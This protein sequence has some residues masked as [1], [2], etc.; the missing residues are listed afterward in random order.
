MNN[1]NEDKIMLDGR[2]DNGILVIFAGTISRNRVAHLLKISKILNKLGKK[3]TILM[4]R[5]PIDAMIDVIKN[6]SNIGEIFI[7]D[8]KNSLAKINKR[9]PLKEW[10]LQL[11]Q[12]LRIGHVFRTKRKVI[13]MG[14]L[15]LP[16]LLIC[17][18][19]GK[20]TYTF[21]GGFAY[22]SERSEA[23]NSEDLWKIVRFFKAQITYILEF[24]TILF[25]NYLIVESKYMRK[26]I[27]FYYYT[28]GMISRKIVDY[29]SLFIDVDLFKPY[30]P[31]DKRG[32]VVGYIGSLEPYRFVSQL[33][34]A[35]RIIA[36]TRS[37]T[38][39]LIIGS[40][41]LYDKV[42]TMIN[43]DPILSSKVTLLK[44][45]S[46]TDIPSYL[47]KIKVFLFLT[48]SD[49]LPN[50]ILEALASGCIV[51]S[52]SIGGIPSIVKEG[53]TGFYVSSRDPR[54]IAKRVLEVLNM[55]ES[56]I[57]RIS[58]EGHTLVR[59]YYDFISALN[60]WSRII[61]L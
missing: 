49:G 47:N 1:T 52:T 53:I 19:Y 10:I 28:K 44:Y 26:Y 25:T 48:E 60:R 35:F 6:K 11:V 20:R 55:P 12:L 56:T 4:P 24:F 33:V 45:V 46:Y 29:G 57:I 3:V 16:A 61:N 8:P 43:N 18:F 42:Y 30:I 41:T 40:G 50:T 36:R 7:L 23:L 58:F 34:M 38:K 59:S 15:N 27:P 22:V 37:D 9:F 54:D 14:T 51:I 13:V 5:A 21:A 39:F 31:I 17:R 2:D 32:N